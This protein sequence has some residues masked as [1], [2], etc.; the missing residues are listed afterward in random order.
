M[1]Y[2]YEFAY[3]VAKT[4]VSEFEM[5]GWELKANEANQRGKKLSEFIIEKAMEKYG[6]DEKE[7]AEAE[8]DKP[9]SAKKQ[10]IPALKYV[11]LD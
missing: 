3:A 9:A 5:E 2:A 8:K 7:A 11:A 6:K 10:N 1:E 4:T